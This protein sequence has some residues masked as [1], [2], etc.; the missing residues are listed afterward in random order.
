MRAFL[1]VMAKMGFVVVPLIVGTWLPASAD[2]CLSPSTTQNATCPV[3]GS[4]IPLINVG[5]DKC[6]EPTAQDGHS[7][8]AG[9]LIQQRSCDPFN[10]NLPTIQ[11]YQFQPLGYVIYNGQPPWYCPGCIKLG[12]QGFFIENFIVTTQGVT[13]STI[14]LCLDVRDG[15]KNDGAVVQQWTCRNS[16]ARSMVWYTSPGDF[17]GAL[18]IRNVNSNLCLDV[19]GGSSADGAQLQQYHCTS[20]NPAQNFW[21]VMDRGTQ[22]DLNGNWTDGSPRSA[23]IYQGPACGQA[24]CVSILVDMSA[25]GR[26]NA[27]GSVVDP[28]TISVSF[29]DDK[30]YTG[31]IQPPNAIRWSNGSIW[32]K[33]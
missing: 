23:H 33:N 8:W 9:L 15:A 14:N 12:A 22:M 27:K 11:S 30:T 2:D 29:P 5:S 32:T 25:F 3:I 1:S 4:F 28:S 17:P 20:N 6:F 31:Q 13:T 21:Q 10:P 16:S 19:K 24:Q 18:K 26:P 7:D